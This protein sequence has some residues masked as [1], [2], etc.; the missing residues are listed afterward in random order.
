MNNTFSFNRFF[1]TFVKDLNSAWHS[2]GTT[3]LI[4]VLIPTIFWLITISTIQIPA[5]GRR[6]LL[7]HLVIIAMIFAPSRIYGNCNRKE[8]G[9][10]FAMLPASK[11]EKFIS[12]LAVCFIVCPICTVAATLLLDTLLTILPV[13]GYKEF[14]FSSPSSFDTPI[15]SYISIITVASLFFFT[16]TL[17]KKHKVSKTILSTIAILIILTILGIRLLMHIET[18]IDDYHTTFITGYSSALWIAC[19]AVPSI[20]LLAFSYVRLKKMNY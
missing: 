13:G 10:P 17:F 7:V 1:K 5:D 15:K 18:H 3:M 2:Y 12:M 20:A 14:I 11:L 4:I 9:I 19:N 6:L 8:K 16:N